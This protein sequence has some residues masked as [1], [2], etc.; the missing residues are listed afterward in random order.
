M[1]AFLFAAGLGTRL[2]PL[3][4]DRPKALVEV[5]GKTLL[6]HAIEYLQQQGITDIVLNIH[7]F[8]ALVLAHLEAHHNFG[9]RIQI[10]DERGELLETGGALAKAA[11]LLEGSDPIVL[12]NV[13]V[14]TNLN[15]QTMLAQ[16]QSQGALA[17]LAIR[18]RESS[19]YLLF[20]EQQRL[21]GWQNTITKEKRVERLVENLQPYAFSGIHII[22][23]TL[24]SYLPQQQGAFSII[25]AYLDL[26]AKQPL[27]GYPHDQDYWF[28][29]GKPERLEAATH[30]LNSL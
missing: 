20:D 22:E 5:A 7:H 27:I 6:Q 4:N 18:Q 16:H 2:R 8:G 13:D 3:T 15:I 21:S 14:L 24:L 17:T 19:R 1:R 30:F 26:A 9:C 12:Y 25:P 29:V 23:P 10:S 28:D 11:P